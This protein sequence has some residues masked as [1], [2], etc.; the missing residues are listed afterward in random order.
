MGPGV[1]S[2]EVVRK[3]IIRVIS[4]LITRLIRKVIST[5]TRSRTTLLMRQLMSFERASPWICAEQL[6]TPPP[7]MRAT[8]GATPGRYECHHE[9]RGRGSQFGT[10]KKGQERQVILRPKNIR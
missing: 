3:V 1:E 7:P 6:A 10:G 4:K 8:I 5:C 9:W 2:T